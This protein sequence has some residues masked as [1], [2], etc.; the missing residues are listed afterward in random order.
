[1]VGVSYSDKPHCRLTGMPTPAKGRS[2]MGEVQTRI[3]RKLEG[4]LAP[5][6][7]DIVDESDRH[8]GHA[9]ARPEGETHFRVEIV[10]AAFDGKS[11][12][13]R[14]RLVYGVLAEELKE[15]VHALALT[16]RTPGEVR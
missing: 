11:R 1:M 13:D 9:G 8:A 12:I 15:R 3:R 6:R 4:A 2:S 14:Q 7:L 16:T 5:E 10:S